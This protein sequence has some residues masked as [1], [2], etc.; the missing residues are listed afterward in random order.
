ME[1][2]EN[3]SE[4]G[5]LSMKQKKWNKLHTSRRS[6]YSPV[7]FKHDCS[8]DTYLEL[9]RKKAIPEHLY[10]SKNFKIILICIC[11]LK[12][13]HVFLLDPSF[14]DIEFYYFSV[15]QSWYKGIKWVI[16]TYHNSKRC[17]SAFKINSQTKNNR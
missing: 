16:V 3:I 9:W 1:K 14:G 13:D 5:V 6:S 15:D 4:M 8:L 7:V 2:L 17:L 10:F 11:I 12:S